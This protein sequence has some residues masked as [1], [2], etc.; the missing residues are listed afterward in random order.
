MQ[1]LALLRVRSVEEHALDLHHVLAPSRRAPAQVKKSETT[2][3]GPLQRF[4]PVNTDR[5]SPGLPAS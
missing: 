2:R 4:L 1:L 5:N 3:V